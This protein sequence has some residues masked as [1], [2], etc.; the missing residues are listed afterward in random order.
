MSPPRQALG[1]G[2]ARRET[3]SQA[4]PV[5]VTIRHTMRGFAPL[6]VVVLAM[7]APA[8]A[9][10]DQRADQGA[11]AARIEI[12][13]EFRTAFDAHRFKEA[14]PLA[15]KLVQ[16]TEDQYGANDRALVNPLTNLGT[17]QYRLADYAAA[18]QT[19]LRGIKIVED[20]GAGADRLLLQPLHGLGA[21]YFAR[22]QYEEAS[23]ILKRALDLSR[24]LDGLFNAQQMQILEPLISSLVELERHD[25]A[26]REFQYSVR[27]AEN[28]Y[29]K[30][31]LHLLRPLDRYARWTERMGRYTTARALYARAL[32]I[33]EQVAGPTS[34]LTVDPLTGIA[35]SY[36]LELVNGPEEGTDPV[37]DP[38]DPGTGLFPGALPAQRLN[39]GGEQAL[40]VAIRVI[41]KNPPLDHARRA[42]TLVELGDWYM[43]TGAEPKAIDAYRA[44]WQD[45]SLAG[46]TAP[47][48]APRLLTYHPP[49]SAITRAH[50][51]ADNIEEHFVETRFTVTRDGK[52]TDVAAISSDAPESQQKKVVAAV[53]RAR[54]APRFE[55]GD[56]VETTGVTLRERLV[57]KRSS[58]SG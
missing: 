28:A 41:E 58:D 56:P 23:A 39:P 9:R 40:A 7:S 37:I 42:D 52:V 10:A 36:R 24:N 17:T 49:S 12:Y 21:T 53:K 2:A 38:L 35:R 33:A 19:Y 51:N 43:C 1:R 6:V 15:A 45:F 3:L 47:L 32:T 46:S 34:M 18:E 22:K 4:A 14:L 25:E 30:G 8:I 13:H 16:T 44:A 48:A 50:L 29:G 54:Y 57:T 20:G 5:G 31:D 27:V 55:Q 26:D 11:D